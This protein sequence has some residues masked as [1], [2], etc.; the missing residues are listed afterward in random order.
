MVQFSTWVEV[1]ADRRIT[2]TLPADVPVGPAEM[3]LSVEPPA[4]D[5]N[6]VDGGPTDDPKFNRE[7]AAFY[8]MLPE[9]LKTYRGQYVAIHDGQVAASGPDKSAVWRQA[10]EQFGRV[11]ILVRLVS[12]VPE[13][14]RITS[15]WAV[16]DAEPAG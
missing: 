10:H 3:Q 6:A 4:P 13:T 7:W 12:E 16:R 14:C 1:P 2:L 9:L 11:T 15:V 8:E 5:A